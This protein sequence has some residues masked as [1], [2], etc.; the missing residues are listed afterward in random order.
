MDIRLPRIE[1]W[2]PGNEK[3]TV[4]VAGALIKHWKVY[5]PTEAEHSVADNIIGDPVIQTLASTIELIND[6]KAVLGAR[7]LLELRVSHMSRGMPHERMRRRSVS[8]R[9]PIFGVA[10][11]G[12]VSNVRFAVYRQ[13]CPAMR[14]PARLHVVAEVQAAESFFYQND[15]VHWVIDNGQRMPF[16]GQVKECG[17]IEY[18]RFLV[19]RV[20]GLA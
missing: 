9:R 4:Q 19:R 10:H 2:W 16:R 17:P 11:R 13:L 3:F 6:R 12:L 14:E 8:S 20:G 18:R 7:E 15:A 5:Q 1:K